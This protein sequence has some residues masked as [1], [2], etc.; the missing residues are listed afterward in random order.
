M[1]EDA[2][3]SALLFNSLNPFSQSR[4]LV[5]RLPEEPIAVFEVCKSLD[6]VGG[7]PFFGS[8]PTLVVPSMDQDAFKET[9]AAML[10]RLISSVPSAERLS[11][12]NRNYRAHWKDPWSR[13]PSMADM[14]GQAIKAGAMNL[15]AKLPSRRNLPNG[16]RL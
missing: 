12:T 16:S 2:P 8:A 7:Q 6:N 4:Q 13:I 14:M 11:E 3:W 1:K 5:V 10:F 9:L 15:P